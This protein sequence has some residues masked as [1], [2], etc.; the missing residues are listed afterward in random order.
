MTNQIKKQFTVAALVLMASGLTTAYAAENLAAYDEETFLSSSD[1]STALN[2]T[3]EM[4]VTHAAT[5]RET[6]PG[7]GFNAAI[8]GIG[9]NIVV[10]GTPE[11]AA[12][13]AAIQRETWPG[14]GG[15]AAVDGIGSKLVVKGTPEM[16]AKHAAIQP[17]T[18]PGRG[19]N[20]AFDGFGSKR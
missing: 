6:W 10:K 4:A 14:Q 15:N 18:E 9:S 5:Q 2:S 19:Y 11:M 7:Q 17:T 8:N 12:K 20:A 3:P 13:H 1:Y 16:V